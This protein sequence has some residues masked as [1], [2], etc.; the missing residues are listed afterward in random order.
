M[1]AALFLVVQAQAQAQAQAQ[2]AACSAGASNPLWAHGR[3]FVETTP[4]AN[5]TKTDSHAECCSLC[6]KSSAWCVA[7][8][9]KLPSRNCFLFDYAS[10]IPDLGF[11]VLGV[12]LSRVM[13]HNSELELAR[14]RTYTHIN[15]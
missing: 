8:S 7:W 10:K 3:Q 9:H 14:G 5:T 4:A 13:I 15:Y 2:Q 6:Q 12:Q 1:L 11:V